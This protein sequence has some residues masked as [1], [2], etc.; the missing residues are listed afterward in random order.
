ML[1]PEIEPRVATV[2]VGNGSVAA[3]D[4]CAAVERLVISLRYSDLQPRVTQCGDPTRPIKI[5]A[6][7]KS[8]RS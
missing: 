1:R 2:L 5:A 7:T 6:L 4:I 3:S 8:N